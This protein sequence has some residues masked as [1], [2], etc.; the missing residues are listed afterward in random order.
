MFL[1]DSDV[2][3]QVVS[4]KVSAV[5]LKITRGKKDIRT[6]FKTPIFSGV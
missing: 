2:K 6:T 1:V 4:L 3:E 5:Q